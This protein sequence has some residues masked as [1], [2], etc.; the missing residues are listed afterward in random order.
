M[1]SPQSVGAAEHALL[2]LIHLRP[3]HGYELAE[4]FAPEGELGEVCPVHA[5]LLYA[6][7]KRLEDLGY[8]AA[9]TEVVG[10]RPP[11]HVYHLTDAG[12]AEFWRWLDQPVRRNREIRMDFLLK[13][14]FSRQ[15]SEHDTVRIVHTQLVVAREEFVRQE[16]DLQRQA[17]GSFGRLLHQVRLVATTGTIRWLEEYGAEL[18]G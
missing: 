9:T 14:Y 17:P 8:V 18:G 4:W 2:G 13:L 10:A 5:S 15:I 3:R 16:R 7:L 12:E 6:S 1:R 11:R